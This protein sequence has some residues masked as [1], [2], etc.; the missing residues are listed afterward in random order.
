LEDKKNGIK[1]TM[2]GRYEKVIRIPRGS[3]KDIGKD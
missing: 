1:E 2:E 3:S